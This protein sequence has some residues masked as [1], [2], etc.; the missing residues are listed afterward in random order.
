MNFT[1]PRIWEGQTC[2]ILAGGP[3]L[4]GQDLS[5]LVDRHPW[6]KVIA[7]NDS[8]KL[9]P[10]ANVL[11]F[12]DAA[13]WQRQQNENA[14][15]LDGQVRF[16]DLLYKG[17][18]LHGGEG[19]RE[20]PQVRNVPFSGQVGLELDQR[21]LR[22]GSNS[23]YAAINLAYLF[24]AKKIILLGYDMKCSGERRHWHERQDGWG[25]EYFNNVLRNEFL[26]LFEFLVLP[27]EAAGV[28]V[29]NANPDSALT[30][31]PRMTLEQVLSMTEVVG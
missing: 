10:Y 12:T 16:H 20:H 4:K 1:V 30:C 22:H 29:I 5:L 21:L 9:R 24:G 2:M 8:W 14:F 19:F 25:A 28:E 17:W 31:W 23:G 18:W 11:Y 13:W 3:S 27:L 15:S 7:I 26:P 6:P